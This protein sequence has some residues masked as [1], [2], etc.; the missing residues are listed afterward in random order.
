MLQTLT[1][2]ITSVL[3]LAFPGSV[4]GQEM[5]RPPAATIPARAGDEYTSPPRI[6]SSLDEMAALDRSGSST[7]S[8]TYQLDDLLTLAANNNPTLVQARLHISAELGKALQAGLYPNPV[9]PTK[10]TRSS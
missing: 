3:L 5:L 1:K 7:M 4:L 2:S 9:F 6:H 8:V 10:R